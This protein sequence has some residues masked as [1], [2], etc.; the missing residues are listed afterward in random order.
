MNAE[1]TSLERYNAAMEGE[2]EADPIERLRFFCSIAL[3][4]RDW[5][6]VEKFFDDIEAERK[7]LQMK[8]N[9][10]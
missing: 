3:T 10:I 7:D 5:F 4:G 2:I 6:D 1:K 8:L 9:L